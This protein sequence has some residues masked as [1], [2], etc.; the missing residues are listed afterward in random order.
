MFR[1]R[2]THNCSTAI[3]LFITDE[4]IHLIIGETFLFFNTYNTQSIFSENC[5]CSV[6]LLFLLEYL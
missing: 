3:D 1:V 6:S 5:G 4:D 2:E